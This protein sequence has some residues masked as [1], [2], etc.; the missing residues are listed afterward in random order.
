MDLQDLLMELPSFALAI[1]HRASG[2]AKGK[3][4]G[5]SFL[6]EKVREVRNQTMLSPVG[7]FLAYIPL[8]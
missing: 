1:R 8:P 6:G 4:G 2:G 5:E 7:N 3:V